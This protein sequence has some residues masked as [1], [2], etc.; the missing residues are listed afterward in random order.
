MST[1]PL[2]FMRGRRFFWLEMGMLWTFSRCLWRWWHVTE[3]FDLTRITGKVLS[4]DAVNVLRAVHGTPWFPRVEAPGQACSRC[5]APCMEQRIYAGTRPFC[6]VQCRDE[7]LARGPVVDLT[8]EPRH[9][10]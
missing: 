3:R 9:K 7:F 5:G 4:P 8:C 1:Q 2:V 6:R 10:A